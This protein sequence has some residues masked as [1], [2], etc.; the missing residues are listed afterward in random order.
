MLLFVV[1]ILRLGRVVIVIGWCR[2]FGFRVCCLMGRGG[3]LGLLLL[4][5]RLILR[6]RISVGWLMLRIVILRFGLLL[7][8]LVLLLRVARLV[9][10]VRTCRRVCRLGLLSMVRFWFVLRLLRIGCFVVFGF[11]LR[12]LWWRLFLL[13]FLLVVCRLFFLLLLLTLVVLM[14]LLL[15]FSFRWC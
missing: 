12:L 7:F 1:I 13:S 4:M 15:M 5:L 6:V 8:R 14:I 2:G 3:C 10:R 11:V 9:R